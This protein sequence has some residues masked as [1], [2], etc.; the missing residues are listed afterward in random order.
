MKRDEQISYVV[1]CVSMLVFLFWIIPTQIVV[2][3]DGFQATVSPQ[4]I[5]RICGWAIFGLSFYKLVST[6]HLADGET[7]IKADGYRLLFIGVGIIIVGTLIMQGVRAVG[8]RPLSFWIGATVITIGSMWMSG[9]RSWRDILL[10][11]VGLSGVTYFLLSL[12]NIYVR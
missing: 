7:I 9:I 10:F 12:A 2:P 5:P 1:L 3:E 6:Y 11:S 8:L 4:L